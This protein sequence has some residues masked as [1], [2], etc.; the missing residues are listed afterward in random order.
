M[1]LF[2][3]ADCHS[4]ARVLLELRALSSDPLGGLRNF[5]ESAEQASANFVIHEYASKQLSE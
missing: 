4:G 1:V 5:S 2:E 3:F